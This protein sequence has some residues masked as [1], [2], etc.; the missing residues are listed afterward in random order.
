MNFEPYTGKFP[1]FKESF[2]LG[3]AESQ[4]LPDNWIPDEDLPGFQTYA[5]NFYNTCR[6][7]RLFI[8]L[9]AL[10]LGLDLPK[11]F[12]L[13]YHEANG[14]QL[15]LLHYPGAPT[16]VFESGERGKI[17]AH[18]DFG[19][20]TLLFQDDCGGLE[21]ETPSQHVVLM[22]VPPVPGTVLFN[23]GDFLMRWSNGTLYRVRAPSG[24][25]DQGDDGETKERF[26]M[27][28]FLGADKEKA[29][30]CLPG[31]S[32]PDKPKKYEP[33]KAGEYINMRLNVTY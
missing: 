25:D 20:G 33:I 22:H 28:Y 31:C 18:M 19:T 30:E 26:P 4:T 14:N 11:D 7:F 8:L 17:G 10:A 32:G 16:S 24:R 9:P 21:V 3:S 27:A 29:I 2:D 15:R 5:T 13:G 1:D 6:E 12:F 23:I